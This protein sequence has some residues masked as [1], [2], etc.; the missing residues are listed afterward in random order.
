MGPAVRCG[1]CI[2]LSPTT[3]YTIFSLSQGLPTYL[4]SGCAPSP[5]HICCFTHML[6]KTDGLLICII[7]PMPHDVALVMRPL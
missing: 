3:L 2:C 4:T 1:T 5:L 7:S 6:V